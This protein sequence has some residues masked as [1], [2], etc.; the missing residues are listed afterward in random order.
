MKKLAS[1]K[2][3]PNIFKMK[4]TCSGR[5]WDQNGKVPCYA[6]WEITAADVRKRTHTDMS[7]VTDV[8]YGF[9]CPD[10]GCFT[11]LDTNKIPSEVRNSAPVYRGYQYNDNNL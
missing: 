10:C 6:L 7:G 11:E 2:N 8:Y 9:V 5:G 1:V 4:A 3:N